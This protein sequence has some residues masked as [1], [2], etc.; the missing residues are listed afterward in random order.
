MGIVDVLSST[1]LA[2]YF[3]GPSKHMHVQMFRYA[4][5]A[6]AAFAVDFGTLALLASGFQ[7]NY[8]VAAAISFTLGLIVNYLLAS[9]WV[10]NAYTVRNR[11]IEFGIFALT[12]IVG[13][14]LNEALIWLFTS[15]L[16]VFYLVSKLIAAFVVVIW[17]FSARKYLLYR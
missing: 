2:S 7:V 16:H 14:V 13:L 15:P 11:K 1:P 12:G 9:M 6:I 4:F 10:F 3:Q 5:V 17:N 8:L